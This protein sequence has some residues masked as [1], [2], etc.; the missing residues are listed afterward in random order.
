MDQ[1]LESNIFYPDILNRKNP[2][3]LFMTKMMQHSR[4]MS[5]ESEDMDLGPSSSNQPCDLGK[6]LTKIGNTHYDLH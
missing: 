1:K 5:L 6:K 3:L 2:D 4:V